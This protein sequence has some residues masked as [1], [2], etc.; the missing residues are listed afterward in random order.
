[1]E[2]TDAVSKI[3]MQPDENAPIKLD[4]LDEVIDE[5]NNIITGLEQAISNAD[6]DNVFSLMLQKEETIRA[7]DELLADPWYVSPERIRQYRSVTGK[8]S[9]P[10]NY[11]SN[12]NM[13]D[14][15]K[16]LRIAYMQGEIDL[17]TLI[18]NS[19]RM[20]EMQYRE[21]Q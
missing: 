11:N 19:D 8:L 2:N 3:E 15:L 6:N 17:E 16:K 1:M 4:G 7:R 13:R 18:S 21:S 12:D 14:S 20:I 10:N 9:I 5:Y